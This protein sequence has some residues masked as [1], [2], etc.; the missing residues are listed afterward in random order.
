VRIGKGRRSRTLAAVVLAVLFDI[1]VVA[2]SK[3][4]VVVLSNG[5]RITGEIARLDRGRLEFKTD[6]AGTLYLEW[7]N[8]VSLVSSRL[9]EVVTADGLTFLGSLGRSAAQSIAVIGTEATVTLPMANVTMVNAIGRSFWRKLDGSIDLGFSYTKSSGIA[10]LDLNTDAVYRRPGFQGR[11]TTSVTLTRQKDEQEND[12]RG[13]IEA[14]YLRYQWPRWFVLGVGR[15]ETNE[16]LGLKLR[17]QV[18]GAIGPRLVNSNRAQLAVGAGLVF[19]DERGVDSAP[20]KNIEALV[21][22]NTSFNTYD[23]PSTNLN[24]TAQY[25]PS[26]SDFGRR[27]VQLDAGVKREFFRDLFLSFSLYNTFDSRPPNPDAD[28][29]D[30]GVVT[31]IGWSH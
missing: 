17:S 29:N 15:V 19:N 4:D 12:D 14:S 31:S 23:R 20:R 21:F 27:R 30:I 3:T 2:Q 28:Q 16:S 11:L 10:Q 7:D 18:G 13:A 25:F 1:V 22:F 8:L 5:D 26:L 6:D 9:V 24:I